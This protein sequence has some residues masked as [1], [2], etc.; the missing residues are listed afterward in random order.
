MRTIFHL[1]LDAFFVSVERILDPSLI[2]KPVIVGGDPKGR[3]VVAACSYEARKF[4]LHSAMPIRRAFSLC[5]LGIYLHGNFKEYSRY[6]KIVKNILS[7][8]AP[9]IQQAS[10]D[11]YYMDFTG[12]EKIYGNFFEFAKKLQKIVLDE[13]KLPCSIGIGKNKTLAKIGSD[14]MKPMGVTYIQPG[15]ERKFLAPMPIETIP[16]IGKKT[17]IE[18]N[19]KGFYKIGDIAE[20][21]LEPFTKAF[22]KMG[23]DI[24]YK[25]NGEGE[26]FLILDSEPK[27]VSKENTFMENV[28]NPVLIKDQL[29]DMT[30]RVCQNLRDIEMKAMTVNLKLRYT[31]FS[32]LT[33]SKSIHPTDDD[34][35]IFETVWD[36]FN[37][38]YT[39]KVAIR[40]I[41]VGV[42]KF[43]K[44]PNQGSLFNDDEEKRKKILEA[45][46]SIRQKHG[47]DLIKLGLI[48]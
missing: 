48:R 26:E 18:L 31:D 5:P 37:K 36:L 46:N 34:K 4:G 35:I 1:D 15:F 41:G 47:Y 2:G 38:A 14:C 21:P 44:L 19:R 25:A 8:Y 33:R 28:T 30:G 3:G 29:F 13:T 17:T 23:M 12:T 42:S 9:V 39:R 27:S 45:V 11:E 20:A 24:W 22:G 40:L 32:T 16:G 6:S 43:I 10:V 7:E